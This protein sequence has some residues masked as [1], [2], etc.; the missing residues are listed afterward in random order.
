[1]LLVGGMHVFAPRDIHNTCII[2]ST[3]MG[4]GSCHLSVKYRSHVS[5]L[6]TRSIVH[7][8]LFWMSADCARDYHLILD[9]RGRP[10]AVS[11]DSWGSGGR[12]ETIVVF[13]RHG[14]E[15]SRTET[16]YLLSPT[17]ETE[18]TVNTVD[19]E[20]RVTSFKYPGSLFTSEGGSHADVNNMIRIGW[21]K[22]MHGRKYPG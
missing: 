6:C 9:V 15:I 3:F 12:P 13:E 1:M 21:M 22:C 10:S 16:E 19:A 7:S 18:P 4:C 17:H 14:L 20:H 5:R 2:V 11:Y 8:L